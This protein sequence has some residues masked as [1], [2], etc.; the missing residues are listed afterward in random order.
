MEIP[1]KLRFLAAIGTGE[2]N[3]LCEFVFVVLEMWVCVWF[4]D[5]KNKN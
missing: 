3:A 4:V 5:L 2:N 1:P